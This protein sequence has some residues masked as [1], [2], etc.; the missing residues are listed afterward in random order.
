MIAFPLPTG[1][2]MAISEALVL[3]PAQQQHVSRDLLWCHVTTTSRTMHHTRAANLQDSCW[4]YTL[5]D[6]LR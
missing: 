1:F 6:L 4:K 3:D 5:L 2:M